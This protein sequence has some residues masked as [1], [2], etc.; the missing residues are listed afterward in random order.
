MAIFE[1]HM[2]VDAGVQA[3]IIELAM[4]RRFG[5]DPNH[6]VNG[7][8]VVALP[9]GRPV[10]VHL[11]HAADAI[12]LDD[13]GQVVL[14]TRVHNPG[15]GKLALPGGF[16][17]EVDGVVETSLTAA[18]REAVEETGIDA[19]LLRD[20]QPVG[21][22][23]YNRPFDIRRAWNNVPGTKILE[24]QLFAVSTRGFR[25][26]LGGN[27]RETKLQAGD[28][29][30]AVGVYRITELSPDQF[31]VPDHLEMITAALG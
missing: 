5:D 16:L 4:L 1:N 6:A 17:D 13:A 8:G 14:I 10:P 29:A 25:F 30:G 28:D 19:R 31:A 11:R 3:E 20:G 26:R 7:L 9:D 24:G 23:R 2:L 12:I 22:R 18:M 27:L 15:A 21:P